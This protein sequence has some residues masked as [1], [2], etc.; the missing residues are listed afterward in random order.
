MKRLKTIINPIDDEIKQLYNNYYKT[1]PDDIFYNKIEINIL[2]CNLLYKFC[3][4]IYANNTYIKNIIE[5][6]Q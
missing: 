6:K 5:F 3:F 4:F 1:F 2:L